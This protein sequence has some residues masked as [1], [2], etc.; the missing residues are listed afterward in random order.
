VFACRVSEVERMNQAEVCKLVTG[1][2]FKVQPRNWNIPCRE[3]FN[4][5]QRGQLLGMALF[6]KLNKYTKK[7]YI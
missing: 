6:S 2:R 5:G 7:F 3:G 4:R 1:L